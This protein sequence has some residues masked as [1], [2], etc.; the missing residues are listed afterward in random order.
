MNLTFTPHPAQAEVLL[1]PAKVKVLCAGRRF[2]KDILSLNRMLKT[3]VELAQQREPSQYLNPHVHAWV[4][5][6]SYGIITQAWRDLKGLVPPGWVKIHPHTKRPMVHDT[7]PY[8]MVLDVAGPG[9]EILIEFKSADR[10]DDLVGSGLDFLLVTE[11]ARVD[12]EAWE[13][14]KPTLNSPGRAGYAILNSTPKGK[15]W[16]YELWRMGQPGHPAYDPKKLRSW[17]FPTFENPHLSPEQ[18]A[19]IE[20]DRKRMG[21]KWFRQEYLAEFVDSLGK[22]IP[23]DAIERCAVGAFMEPEQGRVYTAGADFGRYED[24]SV[25]WI[26]DPFSRELVHVE[27]VAPGASIDYVAHR[28]AEALRRY[29]H[30]MVWADATAL[31]EAYL[32]AFRRE[33]VSVKP[34]KFSAQTKQQM[35]E[36]MIAL[37][38]R[39]AI[40]FP[41]HKKLIE[42]LEELEYEMQPSGYVRYT[43]PRRGHDDHVMALALWCQSVQ[44]ARPQVVMIEV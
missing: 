44:R 27:E 38:E 21:E 9:R 16:F 36:W 29:N 31:G 6:P 28:F 3:C 1:D 12:G 25:L 13:V 18:L 26:G 23:S 34:V 19:D 42:Q 5:G 35:V 8:S 4:V 2:G 7:P 30:A 15:N 10:P 37:I 40:R 20:A 14:V 22:A 11:A 24:D 33:G 39:G 32:E 17:R 43:H 41:P